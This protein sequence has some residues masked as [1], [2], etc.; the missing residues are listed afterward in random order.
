MIYDKD[1]EEMSVHM[2]HKLLVHKAKGGVGRLDILELLNLLKKEV[3]E[4]EEAIKGTSKGNI[5]S[6]CADVSNF[7]MFI[8]TKAKDIL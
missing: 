7:A 3:D 1:I 5:I 4:L 8:A 2:K 6:E